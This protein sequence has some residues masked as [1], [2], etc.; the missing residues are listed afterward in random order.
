MRVSLLASVIAHIAILLGALVSW[1]SPRTHDW[2]PPSV[3][4]DIV[5]EDEAPKVADLKGPIPEPPKP[6]FPQQP[7]QQAP[8]SA[9]P[10]TPPTA[11]PAPSQQAQAWPQPTPPQQAAAPAPQTQP[12]RIEAPPVAPPKPLSEGSG[13]PEHSESSEQSQSRLALD[14]KTDPALEQ[15]EAAARLAELIMVSPDGKITRSTAPPS[16]ELTPEEIAELKSRISKCWVSPATGA[17][18]DRTLVIIRVAFNPDGA[19]ARDPEL[20]QAPA[21]AAG[22]VV[23]RNAIQAVRQCGP[24]GFLPRQK[25]KDWRVLDLAFTPAGIS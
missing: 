4:V 19:V 12:S 2:K 14:A 13:Q 21:V 15:A 7:P 18:A 24:Y 22:P 17:G 6:E 16:N 20:I 23:L 10:P 1:G 11:A 8:S 3:E 9:R 25:Y 5:P